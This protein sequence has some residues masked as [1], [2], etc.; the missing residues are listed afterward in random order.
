M[1]DRYNPAERQ[2]LLA[3]ARASIDHG[4]KSGTALLPDLGGLPEKF[5]EP[6]ASFV[7]LETHG[8]LRGCI[9]RLEASRPLATDIAANAYAAAFEDPRF[10]PL[11][12]RETPN[13]ELH[14]SILSPA[15]PMR[16]RDQNDLIAQLR[17]GIDGLILE[18]G[19]HRGTFL[20]SVWDSLPSPGE[21]LRH[22]K[23]K[24]GLAPDYWSDS[25]RVFRYVTESF[26]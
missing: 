21:F 17:P 15:Q 9:G 7:T 2:L 13:L 16:F 1:A 3:I 4:L 6:G 19:Y 12:E 25:L 23:R 24:A 26:S 22:L 11:Q 5:C 10:P 14:L 18:E 20:P 8:Q